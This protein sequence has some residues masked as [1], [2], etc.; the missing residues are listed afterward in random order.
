MSVIDRLGR[1]PL[2]DAVERLRELVTDCPADDPTR[3]QLEA[4]R[5]RL[6]S[7]ALAARDLAEA[8]VSSDRIAALVQ[9]GWH[10]AARAF[11]AARRAQLQG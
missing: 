10:D 2:D 4:A 9:R 8:G 1:S 11:D 5:D 7:Y 6:A 3:S